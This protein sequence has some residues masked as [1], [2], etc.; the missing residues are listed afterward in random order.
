MKL[1]TARS[2]LGKFARQKPKAAYTQRDSRP[3]IFRVFPV[4]KTQQRKHSKNFPE[5]PNKGIA[6]PKSQLNI[7]KYSRH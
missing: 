3:H 7:Q 6:Q 2:N 1:L 4:L 5:N